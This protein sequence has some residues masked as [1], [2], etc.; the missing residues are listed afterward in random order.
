MGYEMSELSIYLKSIDG[1]ITH[2]HPG[3]VP[4]LEYVH[5]VHEKI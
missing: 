3:D 2:T 1:G 4:P 5:A